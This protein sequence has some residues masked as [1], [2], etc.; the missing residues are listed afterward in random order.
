MQDGALVQ[1]EHLRARR[2]EEGAHLPVG[3]DVQVVINLLG[4]F[5]DCGFSA[6]LERVETLAPVDGPV[7]VVFAGAQGIALDPAEAESFFGRL[8][9]AP[10]SEWIELHVAKH[11]RAVIEPLADPEPE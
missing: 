11:L 5:F 3:A 8:P 6:R 4:H 10:G 1:R 9:G 2:R 7:L